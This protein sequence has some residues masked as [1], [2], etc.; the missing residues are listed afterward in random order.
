MGKERE[1]RRKGTEEKEHRRKEECLKVRKKGRKKEG[2]TRGEGDR[3][4]K[5]DEVHGE[6]TEERMES[7]EEWNK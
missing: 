4:R 5:R 3:K 6:R 1:R 2:V 7:R